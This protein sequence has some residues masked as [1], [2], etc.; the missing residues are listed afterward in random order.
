MK[1][2]ANFGSILTDTIENISKINDFFTGDPIDTPVDTT[3]LLNDTTLEILNIKKR[4]EWTIDLTTN[5]ATKQTN[6]KW[7]RLLGKDVFGVLD[8]D[9]DRAI[10][11]AKDLS[12]PSIIIYTHNLMTNIVTN[13]YYLVSNRSHISLQLAINL[14]KL[15]TGTDYY[16]QLN[17][18]NINTGY[19]SG[20]TIHLIAN[21]FSIDVLMDEWTP[22][23]NKDFT[24]SLCHRQTTL[25]THPTLEDISTKDS[26]LSDT[27]TQDNGLQNSVGNSSQV[28]LILIIVLILIVIGISVAVIGYVVFAKER[29]KVTQN[30]TQIVVNP[31]HKP[32]N[33]SPESAAKEPV[34]GG[35][36]SSSADDNRPTDLA[37]KE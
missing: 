18:H 37:F 29:E 26:T 9:G 28:T 12:I 25:T 32:N 34:S 17:G 10:L 20:K 23:E 3:F 24:T 19:M 13:H 22:I 15:K 7:D 36:S 1:I 30:E 5:R 33:L 16:H 8:I 2:Y 14:A 21:R 27:T 31:R 4:N 6:H 35:T 11:I